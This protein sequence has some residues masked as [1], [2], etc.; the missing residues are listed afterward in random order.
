MKNDL[1]IAFVHRR[2]KYENNVSKFDFDVRLIHQFV[3][4]KQCLINV[5]FYNDNK[6][7]IKKH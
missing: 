7:K 1:L 2:R 4:E 5:W 3:N 6:K